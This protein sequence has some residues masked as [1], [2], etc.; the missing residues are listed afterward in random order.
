VRFALAR[1]GSFEI[2]GDGILNSVRIPMSQHQVL[3]SGPAVL[4]SLLMWMHCA[5]GAD[6]HTFTSEDGRK[7][8][9]KPIKLV[10]DVVTLE[11]RT[12]GKRFDLNIEKLAQEDREWLAGLPEFKRGGNEKPAA[13]G[14]ADESG[15]AKLDKKLYPRTRVQIR[16]KLQE[17]TARAAPKGIESDVMA[18]VN[19]LNAYRFLCGVPDEVAPDKTMNAQA[20][21]AA[22]ACDANGTY[23]HELGHFTDICSLW[24]ISE[25]AV[26]VD[27]YIDDYGDNNR[28]K[29]GHRRWCL[30]PPMAKTGFGAGEGFCAM[31]AMDQSGKVRVKD[32]WAYP[33]KGF[34][35]LEYLKGDAWSLYL[36]QKP[37]DSG[38]PSVEIVKLSQR[39]IKFIPFAEPVPGEKVAI[40]MVSCYENAIN[41]ECGKISEPGIYFVRVKAG[42]YKEQY[43]VELY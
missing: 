17:I 30:N 33:G 40:A 3:S 38:K 14:S 41:F 6:W 31:V 9:A 29:R 16:E 25:L 39:P 37:A 4:V 8:E 13:D 20:L 19:R 32:S 23:S 28:E 1:A 11:R 27:N 43:I 22:K 35:P 15:D 42:R 12:D 26:S 21:E 2:A 24:T 36:P 7:L 5:A 10:G 34:Y 18:A